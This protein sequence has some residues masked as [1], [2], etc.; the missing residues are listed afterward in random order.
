M[1]DQAAPLPSSQLNLKCASETMLQEKVNFALYGPEG[2]RAGPASLGGAASFLSS[3]S[4]F[5][6]QR[7]FSSVGCQPK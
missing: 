2:P 1:S 7:H 4:E 5:P 6:S 3:R